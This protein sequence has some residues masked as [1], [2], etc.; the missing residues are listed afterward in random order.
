[1]LR[2]QYRVHQKL[3]VQVKGVWSCG[4]DGDLISRLGSKGYG[5]L[6]HV[7][8]RH[9]GASQKYCFLSGAA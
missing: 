7:S 5:T 4:R 2:P 6:Q 1:M 8:V 3:K 9:G